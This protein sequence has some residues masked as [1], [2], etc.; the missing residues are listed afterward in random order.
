MT[1]PTLAALEQAGFLP[2]EAI[3]RR[4]LFRI[5]AAGWDATGATTVPMVAW[6]VPGRIEV[7]GKHTDYAG[8]RSLICATEQGM[9]ILARPRADRIL[10]VFDAGRGELRSGAVG[11]DLEPL[12][13]DWS[14]YPMTVARRLTADFAIERGADIAFASDIPFAAGVSSSSALVVGTALVLIA[15]N[16]LEVDA[17]Y[18]TAITSP[19]D[20]GGYLGAVE[21]GRPFRE[22]LGSGGVGTLGGSQDQTAILC[23]RPNALAGYRFDPVTFEGAIPWPEGYLFVIASSGV[24][25]E[26]TGAAIDHYNDLARLTERLTAAARTIY[27]DSMTLGN[28]L[29]THLDAPARI[30]AAVAGQG[31]PRL[32]AR[33]AQLAAECRVIIPGVA[34]ALARG[35]LGRF[36]ELVEWSQAGAE[37][38]LRNQIAETSALVSL[39][40]E[41]GAVAASAFG[42]GFGGSVWAMVEAETA[43]VF[44][45]GWI[46]DYLR[47]FQIHR[48]RAQAIITRPAPPAVR[49]DVS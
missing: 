17:R 1:V 22:L 45:S 42:A 3:R 36:G 29:L 10:N 20:L 26:K 32:A 4:E 25:A 18:R 41:R 24:V 37:L 12:R 38:G 6:H 7:L 39:A 35:D 14:N 2:A 31:D 49:L 43:G 27:D 46:D 8:G 19:E 40:R 44:A 9:A 16:G 34:G 21:N 11:A 48:G 33:L 5:A 28:A 47:R 30:A 23:S 13:G 15:A